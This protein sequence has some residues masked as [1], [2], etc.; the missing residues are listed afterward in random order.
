MNKQQQRAQMKQRRA[1]LTPEQVAEKSREIFRRLREMPCFQGAKTVMAY[2]SAFQEPDTTAFIEACL[3]AGKQVIVPVTDLRSNTL[4]LSYLSS[5]QE[6]QKG[7]YGILEPVVFRRAQ[8]LEP[9]LILIP[10]LVFD[11]A[12]GRTGFGKGYYDRLLPETR[13]LK[14]GICYDFQIVPHID[15]APHDIPMD[16]ILTEKREIIRKEGI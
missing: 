7:A 2:V 5:V 13:G 4:S 15:T 8:P 1:S 9:E 10:G 14:I 6:L 11:M 16:M 3:A 12:G